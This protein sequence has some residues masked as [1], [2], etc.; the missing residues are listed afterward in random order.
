VFQWLALQRPILA[1]ML[2]D[3]LNGDIAAL[4]SG[5]RSSWLSRGSQRGG[6]KPRVR[7]GVLGCGQPNWA[8]TDNRKAPTG[9][10]RRTRTRRSRARP[11]EPF[12]L[13]A[14]GR[15]RGCGFVW[16]LPQVGQH[17]EDAAVVGGGGR[18]SELA[19]DARDVFLDRPLG[20]DEAL[21]DRGVRPSLR[22]QLEHLTLARRQLVERT[23]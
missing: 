23:A 1:A 8:T 15:P 18:E 10:G 16:L 4:S 11:R 17:G 5:R 14:G 21:G 9:A 13:A 20:D 7:A 12:A 6:P 2:F 19:E 3:C 22:H